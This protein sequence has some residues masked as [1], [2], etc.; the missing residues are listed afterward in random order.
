MRIARTPFALIALAMAAV[1]SPALAGNY[2]EGDPRPAA[3]ASQLSRA[4][5]A[6]ETRDWMATA[7]ATG[8]PE[9]E[10]RAT[11]TV[12]RKTR[13]QVQA[14][15]EAWVASGMSQMAYGEVPFDTAGPAYRRAQQAFNSLRA[16]S[17]AAASGQ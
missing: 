15:A 3:T 16:N 1:S 13:A 7:P 2:A 17:T 5:V 9:G 12:S 4:D 6:H 10:A 11:V 8:Y 14:E